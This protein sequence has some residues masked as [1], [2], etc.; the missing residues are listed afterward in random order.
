MSLIWMSFKFNGDCRFPRTLRPL[1]QAPETNT[2]TSKA[3]EPS[4]RLGKTGRAGLLTS[5]V[6]EPSCLYSQHSSDHVCSCR[7]S[8][9]SRFLHVL[10]Q[11]LIISTY[12]FVDFLKYILATEFG[13]SRLLA[14]QPA[15]TN[16]NCVF[17]PPFLPPSCENVY[18]ELP[19]PLPFDMNSLT[20]I[21][22]FDIC[23]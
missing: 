5:R 7:C 21:L 17:I 4:E 19:G 15:T 20:I 22:M 8:P 12:P 14:L 11:L 1:P 6:I 18:T 9:Q 3:V 23:V 13:S 16:Q 10:D 2:E